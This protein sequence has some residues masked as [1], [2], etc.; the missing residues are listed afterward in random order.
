MHGNG[1]RMSVRMCAFLFTVWALVCV[2]KSEGAVLHHRQPQGST[3]CSDSETYPYTHHL[4]LACFLPSYFFLLIAQSSQESTIG[5]KEG[6]KTTI[7]MLQQT[8]GQGST[9]SFLFF[10]NFG[11]LQPPFHD[12]SPQNQYLVWSSAA[13]T[14]YMF[15]IQRFSSAYPVCNEWL[16][17]LLLPICQKSGHSQTS[18]AEAFSHRELLLTGQTILCKP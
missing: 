9:F 14:F 18:Y 17:D 16:F 13:S 6:N 12:L 15:C 3:L 10:S 5:W 11:E 2:Y 4:T 1:G 8:L 7:W